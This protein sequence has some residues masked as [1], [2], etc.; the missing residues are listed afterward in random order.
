M[1]FKQAFTYI[2][3]ELKNIYPE[4]EIEAFIQ[5]LCR[6]L[7]GLSRF[8]CILRNTDSLTEKSESQIYNII[9]ELKGFKPIQYILRE[10]E[11]YGL[12]F[13]VDEAVLIPRPETEELVEWV[14]NDWKNKGDISVLDIGTGSGC[15]AVTLA[16]KL[17]LAKVSALDVSPEALAVAKKNAF[18]HKVKIEF[19]QLDI[20]NNKFPA[21]LQYD[22]I[23]SNPPYVTYEQ[24]ELMDSNVLDFEPHLA[25]FASEKNP[26]VFYEAIS[27]IAQN[28]LKPNGAIYFEMN[29]EK[30]HETAKIIEKFGF[31]C[32]LKQDI[33][34][35]YRMIKAQPK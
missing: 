7:F 14:I 16:N 18:E 15:I 21:Q 28:H 26:F 13:F 9:Q 3:Q 5:I 35:K 4:T 24:K 2:H 12:R 23:V 22:V 29:E 6:H 31:I 20:L 8:D 11:F 17:P 32:E 19:Y 10:T 30:A 33:N 27:E 1:T 25:L 34:G